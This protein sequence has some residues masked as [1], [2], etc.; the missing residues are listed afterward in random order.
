MSPQGK[1]SREKAIE[2]IRKYKLNDDALGA[3]V[4]A[5]LFHEIDPANSLADV[6]KAAKLL[7]AAN[8]RD[9]AAVHAGWLVKELPE[10][11][12]RLVEFLGQAAWSGNQGWEKPF[13]EVLMPKADAENK[14]FEAVNPQTEQSRSARVKLA[15]FFDPKKSVGVHDE[16]LQNHAGS[17]EEA[18][19]RRAR[20]FE[21]S[22]AGVDPKAEI[23][24]AIKDIE[25]T[26]A[27]VR[28][29]PVE[30]IP[31][32]PDGAELY[33][34][35]VRKVNPGGDAAL[36]V[37]LLL[38]LALLQERFSRVPECMATV[39]D[40]VAKYGNS[41]QAVEGKRAASRLFDR[42][43]FPPGVTQADAEQAFAW[44]MDLHVNGNER[45]FAKLPGTLWRLA[46]NPAHRLH[47]FHSF[48][49]MYLYSSHD[50]AANPATMN[51]FQV[52]IYS[53][54]PGDGFGPSEKAENAQSPFRPGEKFWLYRW[55]LVRAPVD[56]T[57]YF[58]FTGDDWAGIDVDGQ[59]FNFARKDQNQAAVQLSR[60]LH[61]MRIAHGDW[62]GGASM[63]VDWQT[64]VLPRTRFGPEAFS[65]E[66]YPIIM[67]QAALNQGAWGLAQWDAYVG[68][69]PSDARGRMMQ[70][71]TM[72]LADPTRAAGELNKLIAQF[73]GNQHY[74]DRLA[75]CLWR[76]NRR[77]EALKV[78]ADL[79]AQPVRGLW[80]SGN[81][82]LWRD[83]FLGGK[84]PI[85]FEEDYQDRIRTQYDWNA[86]S[87]AITKAIPGNNGQLAARLVAEG[88]INLLA[89]HAAIWQEAVGRITAVVEKEKAGIESAK[90]LAAKQESSE[91]V[92]AQAQAAVARSQQR[93]AELGTELQITQSRLAAVRDAEAKFR[94]AV[95]LRADQPAIDLPVSFASNCLR[96]ASID[97]S[98]AFGLVVRLWPNENKDPVRPYL[99]Y[100][101]KYSPDLG[102]ISW[103]V[104]RLVDLSVMGKDVDGP[105]RILSA[106]GMRNPREGTHANWLRRSC[107]L[108]LQAGNVY[109]FAR[110]AHTLA[111]A[112]PEDKN[113]TVY[114]DRLGEVFEK[115]G[116]STSAEFEY[117]WVIQ[118][119][120][121]PAMKRLAQ[122]AQARLFE[123]QNRPIE[124]L[125]ALSNL[126]KVV[127]PQAKKGGENTPL[128]PPPVKTGPGVAPEDPV[129]LMLAAKCYL[130]VEQDDL[131]MN[132]YERASV[133]PNFGA[134]AKPDRQLLMDVAGA[135]L[136]S[137]QSG[138]GKDDDPTK[139]RAVPA[140]IIERADKVLKIVDTIF[141]FH[142]D[143]MDQRQKVAVTLLRADANVMMRNF[144]R[145]IEE[146]RAAKQIAGDTP[147]QYL[148]DL[149]MGELHLASDN[150]D[151]AVPVFQK[152][153]KMN[154]ADISPLALFWLGTTQLKMNNRDGAIESFR[155]LWERFSENDL[156][157]QAIY[158]IA[159]TYAEQGAFLDAI[160]LYEAVGAIHSLPKEKVAPGDVL[161]VKVWDADYYLGTGEYS[162]PVAV[163]ST[164][165]DEEQ[166]RLDMNKINHSLFLGTIR[167]QLGE[168]NKGDGILQVYGTDM[169]YVTYKDRFKSVEKGVVVTAESVK[170]ESSTS[171]IQVV[172]DGEI[173]VSPTIF[174]EREKSEE[175]IYVEKTEREL[176]EE[177]RLAALS[178]KLQR[179]E[180]VVRP[181]NPVYVRIEDGDLD[182]S[183]DPDKVTV[184]VYTYSPE[185]VQAQRQMTTDLARVMEKSLGMPIGD[186]IPPNGDFGYGSTMAPSPQ[187][188]PRLDSMK[189][190][191][192]ETGPH[193]GIFYGTVKT[194]VNGP[195]AVASDTSGESVAALAI[196]GQNNAKDAWI[197]FIDGKPGKW[198]EVDMKEL[199][200]VGK[201]VWDR[202]DG[203]DD[204]YMIDY[205][206]SFRGEGVPVVVERKDNKSAHRN[207]VLL[208]KPVTCR[209]VRF[210][211]LKFEG[212]AP[213]ISQVEI[214]DKDGKKLVPTGTSPLERTKND[215]LEFNVGDCM[216][217][218]YVDEE[219]IEP[220][221][222]MARTS[223]PLGVA[224]VDGHIDA[225]YISKGKNTYL[226]NYLIDAKD[227]K[228]DVFAR[229]TKRVKCDDVLQVAIIDPDLDISPNPDVAQ[230]EV[231]SS[232]GDS[233]KLDA[234]EI[235]AT[236][237]VFTARIQLSADPAAKD[238]EARLWVRPGDVVMMR[239]LDEQNRNPGHPVYRESFV[240]AD[241]DEAADFQE[242]VQAIEAPTVK[243]NAIEPPNWLF[244]LRE[245]D[246]ALPG[247]DRVEMQ[248][249]SF[250]TRDYARFLVLLRDI[251]GNFSSH[252]PVI[253]GDKP[254][255]ELPKDAD[256]KGPR[257]IRCLDEWWWWRDEK[258]NRRQEQFDVPLAVAGDDIILTSYKDTTPKASAGRTFVPIAATAVLENLQKLGVRSD[259]LPEEARAAGI[260]VDVKDPCMV[261]D[262]GRK[263]RQA[264]IM[265]EIALKKRQYKKMVARYTETLDR[266]GKEIE[267]LKPKDAEKPKPV[268][269]VEAKPKAVKGE[270][271]PLTP[272]EGAAK[273]ADLAAEDL[274]ATEDLIKVAALRRDRDALSQAMRALQTRM[275]SLEQYTTTDAE[276]AIDKAE[277]EERARVAAAP[278]DAPGV[279]PATEQKPAW[280]TQPDWWQ[281]CGGIL[282]GTTLKVRV[283]DPDLQGDSAQV[284]VARLGHYA[285]ELLK[286]KATAVK[287]AKGVFELTIPTAADE[288]VEGALSLKGV[289]SIMMTYEDTVQTQFNDK[290]SAYLSLTSNATFDITGP[291][292]LEPKES[293]HL[294]E[295]VY[296]IVRDADMDKTSERDFVWVS[297]T[298][299]VADQEAV[300]IRETQ[301]HSGVFRGSIPSEFSQAKPNNGIMSAKFGGTF[302]VRYVDELWRGPGKLAPE[303]AAKG[304][305]V[306]GSDGTTEI[307]ARQLKR[308]SLQRDVLFNTALAE[309]ELG[310]SSTLMGAIQRGRQHLLESR[311][312]F[313]L[314]VEQYP[315]D[316]MCAH[317]TY[318][319]GNIEFL[320]GN[321]DAAVQRLQ[322][323]IDRWPKSEFKAKAL[324]KLGTCRMKA[325]QMDKAV[326]SFVNLAYFHKD[327]PLVA[328]AMLALGQHF[329]SQKQY[330]A[331]IGVG[332][333]FIRKFPSHE[334]TGNMYLRV[335]GWLIMEKRYPQAIELLDEAEKALPDSSNM[336]AF[337][338]WHADCIFK[339]SGLGTVE[340]KRGIILLQRVTYDYPD[341]KWAKYAAA[342]LA[343]KDVQQ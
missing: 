69:Y 313:R 290:R 23:L 309:Y 280:Y 164:S 300:P 205:T 96:D 160:R 311:D 189:V 140:A 10:H 101:L 181:G 153:A 152:L 20:F 76:L 129:A 159:R 55:C 248:A 39:R 65:A 73:P 216:A 214:Y 211:A 18:S 223:N 6:E 173:M 341:S 61:M 70:L 29:I 75:D 239:Y 272:E 91:Q 128:V 194:D 77:D 149:K 184:T 219:N 33:F 102:Q 132:A 31:G 162:I 14:F 60:G 256:P 104:D 192:T 270:D 183:K 230:S 94:Q 103:C 258:R 264:G 269:K 59:S 303:L 120:P 329:S 121:D 170:G 318:Y 321:F 180:A 68:R 88:Q 172:D 122:L 106:M 72:V 130:D 210:T 213:A 53:S 253:I 41:A 310:N 185:Q 46:C 148:T 90:A 201:V 237:A 115:A 252:V 134:E 136:L 95:G 208:E 328:D 12:T 174:V 151:Q 175:D 222:P 51:D 197:G 25:K 11:D 154:V 243:E 141:R 147:A 165:G 220:G 84:T 195:T 89:A 266:I 7:M 340:Y 17:A 289:R 177:Q 123:R 99:E 171:V 93:I 143:T 246:Q 43:F 212:D 139:G 109:V 255:I 296:V 204:R 142:N 281:N 217:A 34:T 118:S 283:E 273:G 221:R 158:T 268:V 198:L 337:L 27:L 124:A 215:I 163:T 307:F 322:E 62:G 218:E 325:G 254:D 263:D 342:R 308:G 108:A 112:F 187:G 331:S 306:A 110:N 145:A 58:W 317:A 191:L 334:K 288:G 50:P 13:A 30:M 244:S 299:D 107:D 81:N 8:R 85:S 71:E 15:R 119:N 40:L 52:G 199:H 1:A 87:G 247:V 227:E 19:V 320:L 137:L 293:Y 37:D 297:V 45:A 78:Y 278:K 105:A 22:R 98:S 5:Q 138:S 267:L 314:L 56:G 179:G 333:A 21:M 167:T 86:L 241:D 35:N 126:A 228:D 316:P 277:Q 279:A 291:D 332:E 74:R 236:A 196:D 186:V 305:F 48:D 335:A 225:V 193:T 178:A 295:D 226:G 284:T 127:I 3:D 324:F 49:S 262:I 67:S 282:P 169:I 125:Q 82:S 47:G 83:I 97:P 2:L 275:K 301:P 4:L 166:L 330:K 135:T 157:R 92:R 146:I 79:A 294:G 259:V 116:N 240:F 343:E 287:D 276:A 26:P 304:S 302:E 150:A 257:R 224:Y 229:R 327:S 207:E 131:A 323:V 144:P 231:I 339:T 251:D 114:L 111:K 176:E 24:Q 326:E 80:D 233:A 28:S 315:D 312:K 261:I 292:F 32:G 260:H 235:D 42:G 16:F 54:V 250:A 232:S 36:G 155:I 209:W 156:V 57:Y 249:L 9:V 44:A 117:K 265:K 286:F 319:M 242:G 168:A 161:T 190:V 285:P 271:A 338:Y 38:N 113:S 234:K 298:S 63:Q 133:Q 188:R 64:P 200:D 203:A 66:L 100:I 206:V 336:P 182:R 238:D 202:G 245:P 274:Y